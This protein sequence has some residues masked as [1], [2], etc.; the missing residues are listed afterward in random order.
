MARRW[1]L[2]IVC[3]GLGCASPPRPLALDTVSMT[4]LPWTTTPDQIRARYDVRPSARPDWVRVEGRLGGASMSI[5]LTFTKARLSRVSTGRY[6]DPIATCRKLFLP[7]YRDLAPVYGERPHDDLAVTWK[8]TDREIFLGCD[9]NENDFGVLFYLVV[10]P[11]RK[12]PWRGTS[13][14]LLMDD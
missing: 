13:W 1:V 14:E 7:A 5:E 3:L 4:R 11:P 12:W 6:V 8:T 2:P 9:P 10:T